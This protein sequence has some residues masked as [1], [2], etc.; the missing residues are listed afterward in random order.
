MLPLARSST[1]AVLLAFAATASSGHAQTS[2]NATL[3]ANMDLHSR[4]TGVWSISIP[5][6]ANTPP[7][8][9]QRGPRSSG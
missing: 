5:M 2:R 9:R 7:S 1:F 8:A 4:Y 3:L 6:A